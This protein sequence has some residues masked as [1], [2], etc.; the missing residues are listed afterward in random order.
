MK[1]NILLSSFLGALFYFG[2][3][4]HRFGVQFAIIEVCPRMLPLMIPI[5]L[6]VVGVAPKIA[7]IPVALGCIWAALF[8]PLSFAVA[9]AAAVTLV[10]GCDIV[11]G[12][13]VKI[14]D[15][16]WREEEIRAQKV[17]LAAERRRQEEESASLLRS[18][19]SNRRAAE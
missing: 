6:P 17:A 10:W 18:Y 19:S 2:V 11:V 16:E 15:R 4:A 1:F 14:K 12:V 8:G 9:T 7:L 13:I 5:L 3:E